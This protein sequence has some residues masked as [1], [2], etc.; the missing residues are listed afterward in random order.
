MKECNVLQ[1]VRLSYAALCDFAMDKVSG[2]SIC[3]FAIMKV[4]L[5]S[6]GML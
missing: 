4:C 2:F 3:D 5:S 6:I 1:N